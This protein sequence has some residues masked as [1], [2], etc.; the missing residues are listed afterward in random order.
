MMAGDDELAKS[1]MDTIRKIYKQRKPIEFRD[2]S[3][4][5]PSPESDDSEKSDSTTDPK[6]EGMKGEE[7]EGRKKKTAEFI[8][9]LKD[10]PRKTAKSIVYALYGGPFWNELSNYDLG[11]DT[12]FAKKNE[13]VIKTKKQLKETIRSIIHNLISEAESDKYTYIG[14]GRYKEKGKEKDKDSETFQKTDSGDFV[15]FEKDK[16]GVKPKVKPKGKPKLSADPFGDD[17]FDVGGPS[18]PNVPKGAKTS[19]QAIAMNKKASSWTDKYGREPEDFTDLVPGVGDPGDVGI[20]D[21]PDPSTR[22]GKSDAGQMFNVFVDGEDEPMKIKAKDAKSARNQA[23]QKIQNPNVKITAEPAGVGGPSHAD[24]PKKKSSPATKQTFGKRLNKNI[25]K[26]TGYL[27]SNNFSPEDLDPI[28]KQLKAQGR[29]TEELENFKM[30]IGY[31]MEDGNWEAVGDQLGYLR[32][33][34]PSYKADISTGSEGLDNAYKQAQKLKKELKALVNKG[35]I[36]TAKKKQAE[37]YKF[38]DEV[39]YPLEKKVKPEASKKWSDMLGQESVRESK[40]RRFT[41]KEVRM[42]MKK[43]EE[44]RYKKVY[45]SDARRVAWMVNNEGRTLDEM[46]MSMKKKWTKA[47]YGRERYLAKEFLKSKKEQMMEQKLRKNIRESIKKIMEAKIVRFEIP[48]KDKKKVQ[49]IVKKLRFKDGKDYAIY[50]S[51]KTF[52][53]ELDSK[54]E[55]KVLELL[56]KM[57]IQVRG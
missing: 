39:V 42:W 13:S 7:W 36:E 29:D 10:A 6:P 16:K 51:G 20:G 47:Q 55:D 44:N 30:D 12:Y 38:W 3:G 5:K 43:L 41:V 25:D 17:E 18:Y 28:I 24:V 4:E 22:R 49:S 14:F 31:D 35:D 2:S 33:A 27:N 56:M 37:I 8:Q 54:H 21:L 23:Y 46:P 34:L 40:I 50:G 45:N 9:G 19:K 11:A 1:E 52:E 15:P 26:V 53:I 32:D 57:K 48:M